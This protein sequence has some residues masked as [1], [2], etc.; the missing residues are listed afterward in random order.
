M[1]FKN[2]FEYSAANNLSPNEILDF[3]IEDCNFSR[4]IQSTKNV[5][6]LGERGSGKTMSLLFNSFRVQFENFKRNK[7]ESCYE[8]I[9]IYIPCNTPLFHKREYLLLGDDFRKS[10]ICE[11]LL[12][13]SIVYALVDTLEYD[14]RISTYFEKNKDNIFDEI[15]YVLSMELEKPYS[16][17]LGALKR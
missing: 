7:E 3:Y 5:F 12:V 11:H 4:F 6:L 9:G 17:I 1:P 13:L 15:T 2:P 16:N 14:S 8:K 10:V